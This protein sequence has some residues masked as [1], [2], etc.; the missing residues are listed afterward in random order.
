MI[1]NGK[2]Y[3]TRNILF[4]MSWLEN[5]K[6]NLLNLV[7]S[8]VNTKINSF[9]ILVLTWQEQSQI[10]NSFC[11]DGWNQKVLIESETLN[12][13]CDS[14]PVL[15]K[16]RK[17]RKKVSINKV[18]TCQCFQNCQSRK[19]QPLFISTPTFLSRP[20]GKIKC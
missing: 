17:R 16:S 4:V 1:G 3:L 10:A 2:K 9:K 11:W 19:N 18:M 8:T 15:N 6:C 13:N 20:P 12:Q 14:C 5:Q 7:V